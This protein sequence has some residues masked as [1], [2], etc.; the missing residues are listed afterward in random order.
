MTGS[1]GHA[2]LNTASVK[3]HAFV[4]CSLLPISR[5]KEMRVEKNDRVRNIIGFCGPEHEDG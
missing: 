2:I 5:Q 4:I 3:R 1:G